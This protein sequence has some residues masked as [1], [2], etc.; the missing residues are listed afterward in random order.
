M[1]NTCFPLSD[2][3]ENNVCRSFQTLGFDFIPD[4]DNKLWLLEVNNNPS[5]NLDTR[6]DH[7]IKLPLLENIFN[8]LSQTNN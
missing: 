5:L 7:K 6:I 4:A 8:I 2:R 1:Y 3:R